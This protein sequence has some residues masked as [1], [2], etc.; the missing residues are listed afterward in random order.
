M[1]LRESILSITLPERTVHVPGW[2]EPVRV[3]ALRARDFEGE[4]MEQLKE[5]GGSLAAQ[6]VLSCFD[7]K[8][9][10]LFTD[11]DCAAVG[12]LP[13]YQLKELTQAINAINGVGQ[14]GLED[15]AKNSEGSPGDS[16]S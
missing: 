6:V 15:V 2:P 7:D 1:S 13:A 11:G 3:R 8:G 4:R 14:E 5:M 10:P 9:H 16:S 12:N